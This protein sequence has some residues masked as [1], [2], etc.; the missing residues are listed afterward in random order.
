MTLLA[1]ARALIWLVVCKW[2]CSHDGAVLAGVPELCGA[3][4]LAA[5]NLI[6]NENRDLAEPS[7]VLICLVPKSDQQ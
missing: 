7:S 2:P 6:S 1:S 4:L 3:A 5:F